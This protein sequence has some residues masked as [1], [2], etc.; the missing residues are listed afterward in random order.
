MILVSFI[1]GYHEISGWS[2]A[3]IDHRLG[4]VDIKRISLEELATIAGWNEN[5]ITKTPGPKRMILSERGTCLSCLGY[6]M[7]LN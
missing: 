5:K 7:Y 3:E 6:T 2:V 1:K 4:L